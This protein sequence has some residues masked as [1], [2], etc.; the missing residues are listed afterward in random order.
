MKYL[1]WDELVYQMRMLRLRFIK[2]A[3]PEVGVKYRGRTG[4]GVI[5]VLG[6][7]EVSVRYRIEGGGSFTRSRRGFEKNFIQI[8]ENTTCA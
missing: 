3:V 2:R 4:K 5:E 6:F 1:N 8:K 7:D